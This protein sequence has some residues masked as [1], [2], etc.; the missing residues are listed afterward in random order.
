MT[1]ILFLN[2]A[3]HLQEPYPIHIVFINGFPTVA[4]KGDTI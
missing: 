3:E 4:S 2:V 1:G